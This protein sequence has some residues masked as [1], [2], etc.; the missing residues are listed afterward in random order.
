L[1]ERAFGLGVA[2]SGATERPQAGRVRV[3]ALSGEFPNPSP[4]GFAGDL[5]LR[6]R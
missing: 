6:E 2:G 1:R 5:S 4:A 3:Y